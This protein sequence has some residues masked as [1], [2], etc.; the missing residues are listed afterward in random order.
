[1][2]ASR[3]SLFSRLVGLAANVFN[4]PAPPTQRDETDAALERLNAEFDRRVDALVAGMERGT[5]TV[6]QF[7]GSMPSLIKEHQLAAAVL[8]SGGVDSASPQT[9]AVAQRNVAEQLAYFE[10]WKTD[11]LAKTAEGKAPTPKA[12]A[13]RAKM[14][15]RAAHATVQQAQV[16]AKGVP[17]MPFYPAQ[18]TQCR[19]NCRCNWDIKTL[20]VVNANYDCYYRRNANESCPTCI[21]RERAANPLR[22]RKGVIV[23]AEKYQDA[24]LY[25]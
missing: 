9:L 2:T 12:I 10:R 18:Q 19:V 20:D 24:R 23:D 7:T 13:A 6:G 25:A 8:A 17:A 11:L 5:V 4:P 21:A 15:G 3:P 16:E 14:Y 1:M 22:V